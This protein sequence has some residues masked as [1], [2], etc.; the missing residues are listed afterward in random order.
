MASVA[1]TS[2]RSHVTSYVGRLEAE[3]DRKRA[4]SRA[5]KEREA[6]ARENLIRN[7]SE[8]AS[9]LSTPI[10]ANEANEVVGASSSSPPRRRRRDVAEIDGRAVPTS[11]GHHSNVEH[12]PTPGP[13]RTT[14]LPQANNDRIQDLESQLAR[15]DTRIHELEAAREELTQKVAD[16]QKLHK[17]AQLALAD[18][19]IAGTAAKKEQEIVAKLRQ[20]IADSIE[21]RSSAEREI[22]R[23]RSTETDLRRELHE[24]RQKVRRLEAEKEDLERSDS[25]AAAPVVAA[26]TVG[27]PSRRESVEESERRRHGHG[28][29]H[30]NG[31]SI[32]I[33]WEITWGD[34]K[35]KKKKGSRK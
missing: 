11:S 27:A 13:S 33:G 35:E 16:L 6:Q 4:A 7:K 25:I 30:S 12:P 22:E 24:E 5:E 23:L 19:T 18:A 28:R 29:R 32:K 14:P 8:L 2:P 20:Q 31:S 10:E 17:E 3:T 26:S 9:Y 1:T 21:E 15:Q 34:D